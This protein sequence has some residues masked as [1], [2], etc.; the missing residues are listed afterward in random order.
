LDQPSGGRKLS[1]PYLGWFSIE[2]HIGMC[3]G[4]QHQTKYAWWSPNGYQRHVH[5]K[6]LGNLGG[7]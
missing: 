2:L 1:V 4:H 6:S 5:G 3:F 7:C